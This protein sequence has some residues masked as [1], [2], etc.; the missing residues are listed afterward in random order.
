M[1]IQHGAGA[2]AHFPEVGLKPGRFLE[3]RDQLGQDSACSLRRR[4]RGDCRTPSAIPVVKGC[5]V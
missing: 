4:L 1:L 3:D 5:S 2:P